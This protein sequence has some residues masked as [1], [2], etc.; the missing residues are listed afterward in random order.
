MSTVLR[1]SRSID[2]QIMIRSEGT[3]ASC[4]IE[5]FVILNWQAKRLPY[6]FRSDFDR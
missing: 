1:N 3:A 5:G 6:N 4:Q 2:Q